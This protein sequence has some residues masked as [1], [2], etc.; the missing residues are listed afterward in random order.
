MKCLHA[1]ESF[2]LAD[3]SFKNPSHW[4]WILTKWMK[5]PIAKGV[6]EFCIKVK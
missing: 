4:S 3:P 6:L 2:E 5:S 1:R